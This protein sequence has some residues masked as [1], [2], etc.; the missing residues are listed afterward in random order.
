LLTGA[1]YG[2][3]KLRY[4]YKACAGLPIEGPETEE[5]YMV[6]LRDETNDIDSMAEYHNM[7]ARWSMSANAPRH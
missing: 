6:W 2:L 3:G 5:E 7:I 1:A 4:F